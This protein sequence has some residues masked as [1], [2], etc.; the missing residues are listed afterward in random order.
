MQILN[1]AFLIWS[2]KRKIPNNF[3]LWW[4]VVRKG[5]LERF[6]N[7]CREKISVCLV[8]WFFVCYSRTAT[9]PKSCATCLDQSEHTSSF[10]NQSGAIKTK[11]QTNHEFSRPW[12]RFHVFP[13][14][15]PVGRWH[16]FPRWSW[17]CVL[18]F[19]TCNGWLWLA[20]N[21]QE[22]CLFRPN[23]HKNERLNIR[24]AMFKGLF[25]TVFNFLTFCTSWNRLLAGTIKGNIENY[26]QMYMPSWNMYRGKAVYVRSGDWPV[27]DLYCRVMCMA[28]KV[29]SRYYFQINMNCNRVS[30]HGNWWF[31]K[32]KKPGLHDNKSDRHDNYDGSKR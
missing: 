18:E 23:R 1:S 29:N 8:F 21:R 17:V 20:R 28:V 9:F 4:S 12:Y 2:V 14:L 11:T 7:N 24:L 13:R 15:A 30:T 25:C 27:Q 16:V 6:C 32:R 3:C 31:L 10:F 19:M 22:L 5:E 26:K